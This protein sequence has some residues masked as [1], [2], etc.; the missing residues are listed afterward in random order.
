MG[1]TLV[2]F[3]YAPA[4]LGHLRVADALM[5]GIPADL[6]YC[7]FS[8]LDKPIE[9][10]HRFTSLSLPARHMAEWVQRGTPQTIFTR[11]YRNYLKKSSQDLRLQ[12]SSLIRSQKKHPDK[13]IVVSTHFGL[14]HHLGVIKSDLE[15]E[16]NTKLILVV[17]VTDDSPQYIWYVDTADMI[18]VPSRK[19]KKELEKYAKKEGLKPVC[20]ENI[21][22]PVIPSLAKALNKEKI[23]NRLDQYNPEKTN[24]INVVI[25]VSGAAVGMKFFLHLTQKLHS[26][27]DRFLFHVVCRKAPFTENFIREISTKEHVQLYVS[28]SYKDIV[29]MYNNVYFNYVISSEITK[30]SEQAFKALL[31]N[32]SVGGSFLF[33]ARPVGRQEYDNL[34]FLRK[35]NFLSGKSTNYRGTILP[36][37]SDLSAEIIWEKYNKGLLY[38][39]FNEFLYNENCE[40]SDKG[41]YLFWKTVLNTYN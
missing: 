13:V 22:Y 27:S 23:Q 39:S 36:F 41:V 40:V 4:G 10:I 11:L 3:T 30:P 9:T 26:K 6:Q 25:P 1:N 33:F 8:P 37:G 38:K 34:E 35:N 32:D 28:E 14:A 19:T 31:D 5:E 29:Q 7:T 18:L 16:L 2:V 15:N 17:Q 21:P 12:F 20:I 24:K